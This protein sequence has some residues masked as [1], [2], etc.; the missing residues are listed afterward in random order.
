MRKEEQTTLCSTPSHS[1]LGVWQYGSSSATLV[2]FRIWAF[3]RLPLGG[4]LS[5]VLRNVGR[6][7][8]IS[9]NS[10]C[11]HINLILFRVRFS[12]LVATDDRAL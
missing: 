5:A 10:V 2:V 3:V 4:A 12:L 9:A 6:G 7:R 11:S 1:S 8:Y